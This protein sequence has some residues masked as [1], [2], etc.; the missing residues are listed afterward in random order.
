MSSVSNP[1]SMQVTQNYSVSASIENDGYIVNVT[2]SPQGQSIPGSKGSISPNPFGIHN[3][4][5]SEME[6]Q[7]EG[8]WSLWG[9]GFYFTHRDGSSV[10]C[11]FEMIGTGVYVDE[12]PNDNSWIKDSNKTRIWRDYLSS[13]N[14]SCQFRITYL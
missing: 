5:I 8:D 9:I 3:T 6:C 14:W 7:P 2:F 1:Y 11:R 4:Y 10:P 12:E 13:H